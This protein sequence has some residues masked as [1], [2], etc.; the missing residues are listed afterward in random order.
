MFLHGNLKKNNHVLVREMSRHIPSTS[1][2]SDDETNLDDMSDSEKEDFI[3]DELAL[4]KKKLQFIK[5]QNNLLI[6]SKNLKKAGIT[7]MLSLS[8]MELMLGLY[9]KDG[10]LHYSKEHVFDS[11]LD[12]IEN[13][14]EV[15][16]YGGSTSESTFSLAL[17]EL[18]FLGCFNANLGY[19]NDINKFGDG[20][21]YIV[22]M[23]RLKRIKAV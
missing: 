17:N 11:Q 23:K 8:I 10:M 19:P 13:V 4:I 9:A 20:Q 12:F 18:R 1:G 22:Q 6:K 16:G 5:K 7:S 3:D 2:H 21:K 15:S 14:I